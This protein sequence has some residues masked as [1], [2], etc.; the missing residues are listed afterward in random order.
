LKMYFLL[1]MGIFHCYVSLPEGITLLITGKGA[2][3]VGVCFSIFF[4]LDPWV[5]L[6]QFDS[7]WVVENH[8]LVMDNKQNPVQ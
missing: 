8:H 1:K 4:Y 6:I 7:D 3:L 2:H 5:F